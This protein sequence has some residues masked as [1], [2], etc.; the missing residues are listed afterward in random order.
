MPTYL[1]SYKSRGK[2]YN[3][4]R[5]HGG[6]IRIRLSDNL[7]RAEAQALQYATVEKSGGLGE[8][9]R[10]SRKGPPHAGAILD[11]IEKALRL[12]AYRA[13]KAGREFSLTEDWVMAKIKAQQ[14]RCAVS[15]IPFDMKVRANDSL[16]APWR[17]SLDRI[18][19]RKGYTPD[20]V[21]IVCVMANV[22]MGEWGLDALQRLSRGVLAQAKAERMGIRPRLADYGHAA[23]ATNG[24][25]K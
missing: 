18:N 17:P 15:D 6:R 10:G 20:N 24:L 22:A 13:R 3:Y 23:T 12:A 2:V 4:Y 19:C 7:R 9:A 25:G 8:I 1:H 11:Y 21:R 16:Y 14:Y 5:S